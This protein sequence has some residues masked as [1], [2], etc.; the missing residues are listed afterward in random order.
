MAARIS[1]KVTP[2][3]EGEFTVY[4]ET[5]RVNASDASA[6]I[7]AFDRAFSRYSRDRGV[8]NVRLRLV[9]SSS[10]SF[11]ATF[12]LYMETY[13]LLRDH[14]DI[15][16]MFMH[17]FAAVVSAI[18]QGATKNLP[19]HLLDLA[20]AVGR[21]GKRTAAEF[22]EIVGIVHILIQSD[23]LAEMAAASVDDESGEPIRAKLQASGNSILLDTRAL[24]RAAE[25]AER[26]DLFATLLKVE[27]EWYARAEGMHGV[28]L[29]VKF[30]I[31][32]KLAAV[33]GRIFRV[34][35]SVELGS[36]NYP[37]AIAIEHL[38]PQPER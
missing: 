25:L 36:E 30:S 3:A 33:H 21:V 31:Q 5:E 7:G 12:A 6:L 26:G 27:G 18:E 34:V 23:L 15:I 29:P 8:K 9:R 16:A 4:L 1:T 10:G 13:Q 28:L 22:I 2:P 32:A 24:I 19:K 14:K 17:D 35:G 20:R 38:I 37:V 11:W